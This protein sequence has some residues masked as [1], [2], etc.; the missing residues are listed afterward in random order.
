MPMEDGGT[1]VAVD[2]APSSLPAPDA[3]VIDG[4][5]TCDGLAGVETA[6]NLRDGDVKVAEDS[7]VGGEERKRPLPEEEVDLD[8][9]R[10]AP[11][12]FFFALLCQ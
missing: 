7:R 9:V 11:I 8:D 10:V 1:A 12:V 3:P 4:R 5:A 6:E 2:G